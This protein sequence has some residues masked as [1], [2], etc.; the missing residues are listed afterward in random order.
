MNF[1]PP[2]FT[3]DGNASG[4]LPSSALPGGEPSAVSAVNAHWA[5]LHDAAAVVAM[6]GGIAV[7]PMA[8]E[9]RNFPETIREAGGWRRNLAEQ[10]IADLA[11]IMEPGIAALLAV[12]AR[13]A[14]PT[15]AAQ[16]LWHEFQTARSGLLALVPQSATPDLT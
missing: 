15:A 6:L 9:V 8:P 16:A 10:G 2:H 12:Q 3:S 13:R 4:S 7:E 11:A 1:V 5:A 14:D